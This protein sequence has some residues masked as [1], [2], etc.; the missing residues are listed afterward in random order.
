[1]RSELRVEKISTDPSEPRVSTSGVASPMKLKWWEC[2][3][4]APTSGHTT[5]VSFGANEYAKTVSKLSRNECRPLSITVD[6]P[7]NAPGED[8]VLRVSVDSEQQYRE[9]DENNNVGT[10]TVRIRL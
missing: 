5:V 10:K 2:N 1:L 4:G 9:N 3:S 8:M 6:I 7:Y